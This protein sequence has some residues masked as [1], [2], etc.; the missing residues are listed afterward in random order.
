M[1][2]PKIIKICPTCFT[3]KVNMELVHFCVCFSLII[4]LIYT[5]DFCT[6]LLPRKKAL[7]HEMVFSY[8][9]LSYHVAFST[10]CWVV[11]WKCWVILFPVLFLED[12]VRYPYNSQDKLSRVQTVLSGKYLFKDTQRYWKVSVLSKVSFRLNY[13]KSSHHFLD[14]FW[15]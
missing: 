3:N 8:R 13:L 4:L 7:L 11:I 5:L 14:L 1:W 15:L 2:I 9:S 12:T 10:L 6:L